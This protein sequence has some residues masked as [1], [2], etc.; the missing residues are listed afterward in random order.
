M[1]FRLPAHILNQLLIR[2]KANEPVRQIACALDVSR[3][4]IYTI[5]KNL[6]L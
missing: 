1:V 5:V 4:T 2:L 3:G 6:D